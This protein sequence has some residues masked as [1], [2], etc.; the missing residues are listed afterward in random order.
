MWKIFSDEIRQKVTGFAFSHGITR[1]GPH[2]AVP[3]HM[4]KCC[5]PN[6]QSTLM[7]QHLLLVLLFLIYFFPAD[8]G[9]FHLHLVNLFRRDFQNI[10]VQYDEV[11]PI[12]F[13]QHA[14]IHKSTSTKTRNLHHKSCVRGLGSFFFFAK[15][16]L[17][18]PSTTPSPQAID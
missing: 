7:R 3:L 4:K 6:A 14:G 9:F 1:L 12:A 8:P 5:R 16:A 2:L 10:S 13:F 15:S 18:V 17:P 11:S